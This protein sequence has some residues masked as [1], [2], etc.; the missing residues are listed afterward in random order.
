LRATFGST[1]TPREHHGTV[2]RDSREL[3]QSVAERDALPD[4]LYL[5]L[6]CQPWRQRDRVAALDRG[7]EPA[8]I[9]IVADAADRAWRGQ[10][11]APLHQ[12]DG[13][14]WVQ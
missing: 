11:V 3:I 8:S 1:G 7:R 5:R 12:F 14:R 9:G 10:E 4:A 2:E 13:P 6:E